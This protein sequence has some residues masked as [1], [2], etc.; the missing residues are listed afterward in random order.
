M[1]VDRIPLLIG[2]PADVEVW[3]MNR[4]EVLTAILREFAAAAE[5]GRK[6]DCIALARIWST[7]LFAVAQELGLVYDLANPRPD[8]T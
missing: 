7:V 2:E 1:T 4:T 6:S 5:E 8:L 3:R